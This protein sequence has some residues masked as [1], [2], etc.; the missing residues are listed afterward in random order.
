MASVMCANELEIKLKT[1]A[2]R[3]T[4][5]DLNR[6]TDKIENVLNDE[7]GRR[8]FRK[9]MFSC[10]MNHGRRV[11][12]FWEHIE[13]LLNHSE[14]SE[15]YLQNYDC[16]SEEAKEIGVLD[17]AT[18]ARIKTARDSENKEEMEECLKILKVEATKALGNEYDKYRHRF[19]SS[20][21]N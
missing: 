15:G 5:S 17:L 1:C 16:L 6:Y 10:K 11:L 19:I 12:D 8:H 2:E 7:K 20:S 3:I 4:K 14:Y 18:E 13:K 21:S 9:F